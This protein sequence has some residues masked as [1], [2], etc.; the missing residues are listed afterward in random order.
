MT[1]MIRVKGE[2]VNAASEDEG[3]VGGMGEVV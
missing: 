3:E 2:I 1:M